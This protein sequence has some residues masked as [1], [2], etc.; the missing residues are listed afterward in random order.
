M[1]TANQLILQ[2]RPQIQQGKLT[3]ND[4][5]FSGENNCDVSNEPDFNSPV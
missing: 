4:T 1:D 3:N 5:S 2:F